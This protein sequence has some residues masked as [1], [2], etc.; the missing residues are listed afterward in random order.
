MS[1][2]TFTQTYPV[3]PTLLYQALTQPLM[4]EGWFANTV[5]IDP[6][7]EGRFYAY[8]TQG[9]STHG[10]VTEAKEN[11]KLVFSW[12]GSTDPA[13]SQVTITL[14]AA[15]KDTQLHIQHS[16]LGE[17]DGWAETRPELQAGWEAALL[18]LES[19]LVRGLDKRIF[20]RPFLGIQIAGAMTAEQAK[21]RGLGIAGGINISGTLPGTGAE[22]A[23]LQNGDILV[24]MGGQPTNDFPA[25]TAV[26]GQHKAGDTVKIEYY[27]DGEKHSQEM[28]LSHRPVP[29]ISSDP[30]EF[31][32]EIGK[33][34]AEAN[35]ELKALFEGVSEAEASHRPAAN[36]W[37]ARETVA[38]LLMN[39]YWN[40][41]NV[42]TEAEGQ[43]PPN[44][45]ND[46]GSVAAL[47]ASFPSMAELLQA[48]ERA[49]AAT[50]GALA[51][52]PEGLQ[53]R[54]YSLMNMAQGYQFTPNHTRGHFDQIRNAIAA[55]RE[56]K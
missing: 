31:A 4:L 14:N 29:E 49:A 24:T 42:S 41:M 16:G 23:G 20:D 30:K 10:R 5:D 36:E 7:P 53:Q 17:G 35:Q 55:A 33:L 46:L 44:Y 25:L 6:R 52:I 32:A 56:Q 39:E 37:S 40:L 12:H 54:K 47:A 1:D 3:S 51:N 43:R 2:L 18:N 19:L 34:F 11:E 27:R 48:F 28:N 15:G 13:A 50:V 26:I 8:W 45:A 9:Y 22:A 21:E 38:H